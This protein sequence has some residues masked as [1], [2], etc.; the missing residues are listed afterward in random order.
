[1]IKISNLSKSFAGNVVL[2]NLNLEIN[3]G[4]VIA[5]IGASGAGKSTFLRS[6][7]Y[8]EE[9]DS[10]QLEIDNFKVDFEHIS[11]QEILELRRKTGM[12]FQQF[13][14]F[15][16]RTALQN[17]MEGLIQV[18][19]MS[20]ADA[21]KLAEENLRKVGLEDRM[22]YYPKFLSGG[23]KQR[24]GIARAMAMQPTLL[25]LDEP[26]SAL[27]PELVG[28]V[29]DTI[30]NAAKNKQTMVLVSHEMDFVYN[31]ATKVLFLEKGKIIEEGSPE[32]VFHH[33]KNPRT[34]EFLSRHVKTIDIGS[35]ND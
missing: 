25:L 4:D 34:S 30:L 35:S 28:E 19:K 11:K 2:D 29:Q 9:A 10:G 23:Q 18:K 3:E 20:K 8:L 5:L 13:N 6:I 26:T 31:V 27:D 16:R 22:D 14:L 21:Q 15:E 33:P 7:N 1:M 17:V 12:V 24:V 32:E